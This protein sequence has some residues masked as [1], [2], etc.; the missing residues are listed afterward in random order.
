[1]VQFENAEI[2]VNKVDGFSDVE[3]CQYQDE[4]RA[5]IKRDG[6]LHP[7]IVRR[8]PEGGFFLAA[9]SQRLAAVKANGCQSIEVRIVVEGTEADA[10]RQQVAEN[11]FRKKMPRHERAEL[12]M[13]WKESYEEEHPEVKLGY[14]GAAAKH[15]LPK[16]ANPAEPFTSV[17]KKTTGQG[18]RQT[19]RDLA[20][21]KKLRALSPEADWV[22][23]CFQ[24]ST[25]DRLT[26]A[27]LPED[28]RTYIL[29]CLACGDP[30]EWL[31]SNIDKVDPKKA[32]Y[33]FDH[34]VKRVGA[35]D[36]GVFLRYCPARPAENTRDFDV[37]AILRRRL[38]KVVPKL[39][40]EIKDFLV[41]AKMDKGNGPYFRALRLILNAGNP[42]DWKACDKCTQ[43]DV[44][45]GGKPCP[46]CSGDKY[47]IGR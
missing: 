2:M 33:I 24:I 44:D 28:T 22:L 9:G 21:A 6:L 19:F 5:S 45:L 7:I 46:K 3:E 26:I 13:R 20:I 14:A 16:Q 43:A 30:I 39:K 17:V 37:D 35:Q 15:K 25:D 29:S 10:L 41:D 36:D 42:Q 12:L 4:L 27:D 34:H 23:D 18:E 47:V 32:K 38:E 8:L 11:L 1:M 31:L 40:Q